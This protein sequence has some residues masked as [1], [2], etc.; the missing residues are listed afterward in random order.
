MKLR[1]LLA[2]T[3]LL[4]GAALPLQAKAP[5][6]SKMETPEAP[7]VENSL[8]Q[9]GAKERSGEV[10]AAPVNSAS[11]FRSGVSG[12]F[13]D[14]RASR[15]GDIVTI[16]INI[17]DSA[18]VGNSTSRSR[19]GSEGLG[20]SGFFGL[21]TLL[22]KSIDAGKL[23]DSNSA[24][25]SGG[26]GTIARSEKVDMTIAAIVSGV[27]PNGNLAIKGRQE[28][29][30]NSELRELVVTGY[31][32]PE[33]IARDNTIQ[34][35]QIAEARI[36]YGGRGQLNDAQKMRWGQKIFDAISPF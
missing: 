19:N 32:R 11:L 24:S 18:E 30:I 33:D 7:T 3:T 13:R 35:T 12:F 25:K 27:L 5:K 20:L 15:V 6:M 1:T 4:S 8:A 14:Q 23:V 29:M 36:T 28:V 26:Q 2:V 10:P 9:W 17:A 21:Q 34:H 31:I 16:K 22:P